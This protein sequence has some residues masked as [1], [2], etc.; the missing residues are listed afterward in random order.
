MKRMLVLFI[1]AA[2]AASCFA[3]SEDNPG[4]LWNDRLKN[5][6]SQRT[7]HGEGDILTILISENSTASY[8]A[9]TS[10]TKQDATQ[11][12]APAFPLVGGLF[13]SLG[14]AANSATNGSGSTQQAG[15]YVARMTVVVRK[16]L[17]GGNL[18]IEG[19]RS[20][21]INKD[22]QIV[23]LTGIIRPDD[24]AADNTI[25]SEKIA[26]AI[27]NADGKGQI[28]DRQRQG[29]FTKILSYLF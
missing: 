21:R 16:V 20:V 14:F 9:T 19:A 7:A 29:I 8:Q 12:P 11:V 22:T 10:T 6:F 5:P 1:F 13:K 15:T 28:A 26:N 25:L 24:I 2:F 4:S 27:I 18:E 23:K 17:P 3:Q